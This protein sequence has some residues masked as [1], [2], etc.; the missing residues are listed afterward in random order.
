MRKFLILAAA[1]TVLASCYDIKEIGNDVKNNNEPTVIGF[2]TFTEKATRANVENLEDYH[3]TF[4]VWSTKKS[5]NDASLAPEVVFCGDSIKDIITYDSEKM[6]PNHWTYE[7]YRYWDKQATY[8]FVAVAPNASIVRYDMPNDVANTGGTF[9]TTDS[10]GYTLIGQNLQTSE[11]PAAAEKKVGF[12]GGQNEDTDLMTSGRITRNGAAAVTDVNLQFKHILAKLNVSIAKDPTFDNVKVIIDSVR[13]IGLDDTGTYF[14]ATSNNA[15]SDWSSSLK[16][17]DY[18]LSWKNTDGI[19]LPNSETVGDTHK[20]KPLYFIESLVMPQTIEQQVEK[21]I[22]DYRIKTTNKEEKY[23]Y[24]L[25][26]Y[27]E[28]GYKVFANFMEHNNY[29]IKLTVKPNVITFD[30]CS[31]VWTNQGNEAGIVPPV[32]Q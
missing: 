10:T 9:V 26:L 31:E 11:A 17:Q 18:M 22:V 1:A 23:N 5:N 8:S 12:K 20:E 30:A 32:Q 2:G 16:N 27:D 21:L 25:D 7:D 15:T 13:V 4:A 29:T 28:E 19:E 24:V 6:H 14:E 3:T